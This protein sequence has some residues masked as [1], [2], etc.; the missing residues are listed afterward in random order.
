MHRRGMGASPALARRLSEHPW[1]LVVIGER[2]VDRRI[3]AEVAHEALLRA[4]PRLSNWLRQERDFLIFKGD[5]ERAEK[6]WR[7]MDSP[8]AA[9]LSGLDLTRAEAWLPI[10]S[11]DLTGEVVTFVQRSITIDRDAKE[12]QLRFQRYVS[13]AAVVATLFMAS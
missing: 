9:L 10:R 4:W 2:A 1:R 13:I 8:D 11:P 7:G 12:R 6:R 3:V 5:A